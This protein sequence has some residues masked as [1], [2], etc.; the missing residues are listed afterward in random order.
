MWSLLDNE[1]VAAAILQL[2]RRYATDVRLRKEERERK[3][4]QEKT[5]ERIARKAAKFKT[6]RPDP[7]QLVDTGSANRPMADGAPPLD[8]NRQLQDEAERQ[9][10]STGR[11]P[12]EILAEMLE[13]GAYLIDYERLPGAPPYRAERYGGQVKLLINKEHRLFRDVYAADWLPAQARTALELLLFVLADSEVDAQ[14]DP[15][16]RRFYESERIVWGQKL[17]TMLD[18]L[19]EEAPDFDAASAIA[20]EAL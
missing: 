17:N 13:G 6:R 18:I 8:P 2:R 10:A 14:R 9:A 12:Q 3:A 4:W 11:S 15:D 16:R 5:S 1:G 7:A 20:S 19:D